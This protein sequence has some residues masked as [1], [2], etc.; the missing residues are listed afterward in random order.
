MPSR[1][2]DRSAEN[3]SAAARRQ[4]G[5]VAAAY[6]TSAVH[7]SGADL[8][9]LVEATR[10]TAGE[11]VLDL[12]CGAGHT[13]LAM[14]PLAGD[15]VAVDVTPEMLDVA[16]RLA[17]QRGVRNIRFR[18][19]DATALPFEPASFDVV[20]S[21]YSAHHYSDPLRALREVTR[22]LRP[23]GRFL[24]ADTV[25]PEAPLLDTFFNAVELLRDCSHIRNCRLSEWERLFHSAGLTPQILSRSQLE[26]EGSSWVERSQTPGLMVDA[27]QT[28]FSEA[29]PVI[30]KAFALR[31]GADW[32]WTIP[33]ALLRGTAASGP[34]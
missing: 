28:L 12:G 13:A 7:A 5:A 19:A 9:A 1:S 29:P 11:R 31:T 33:I 26:L 6:A 25:A 20:T 4:F 23:G 3:P 22:V 15:V 34:S 14:A 17:K 32:G 10:C 24:L 16:R 2:K 21:R 27:I 8:T 18:R 30:R